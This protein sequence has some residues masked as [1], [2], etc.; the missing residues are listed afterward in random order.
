MNFLGGETRALSLSQWPHSWP[1]ILVGVGL[2]L[3]SSLLNSIS[4]YIL[5]IILII[6]WR[7]H[8]PVSQTQP[9][10]VDFLR[11]YRTSSSPSHYENKINIGYPEAKTN[12]HTPDERRDRIQAVASLIHSLRISAD[13]SHSARNQDHEAVRRSSQKGLSQ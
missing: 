6:C 10:R 12:Q 1:I 4:Y 3:R 5:L 2:G 8:L 7:A 9:A 13:K 11:S